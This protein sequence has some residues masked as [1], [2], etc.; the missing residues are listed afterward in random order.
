[1]YFAGVALSGQKTDR[2]MSTH[3]QERVLPYRPELI[4]DL[5][6]DVESYPEFLPLWERAEVVQRDD[7][8]Y[9]TD[10]VIRLGLARQ[11]FR[12]RTVLAHPHRIR[13][14]SSDG[15]FRN[16]VIEWD[17]EP[18]LD[19]GCNAS[20]SLSWETESYLFQDVL[21]LVLFDAARSI[22][23]AF[24]KRAHQLYGSTSAVPDV[25]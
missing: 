17:F 19:G 21:D 18:V 25:A 8:G 5:V 10:Q 20:C 23:R 11:R 15:L 16:L 14:T 4:F 24:E 7:D 22:V 12:S 3:S 6:A 9:H 1:M 2:I 13:V